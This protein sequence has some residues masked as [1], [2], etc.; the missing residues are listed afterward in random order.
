MDT[1]KPSFVEILDRLHSKEFTMKS[2]MDFMKLKQEESDRVWQSMTTNATA[3]PDGGEGQYQLDAGF[4]GTTKSLNRYHDIL[5]YDHTRVKLQDVAS[6]ADTNDYINASVIESPPEL[7]LPSREGTYIATQGPLPNTVHDF[8]Q[9]VWEQRCRAIVMLTK[10]LE[11]GRCKCEEY[12]PQDT[13]TPI[14]VP[15]LGLKVSLIKDAATLDGGTFEVRQIFVE[16]LGGEVRSPSSLSSDQGNEGSNN[17]PV[18]REGLVVHHFM[19]L[20]W[21]DHGVPASSESLLRFRK[22]VL[23]CTST[24]IAKLLPAADLECV[25][26]PAAL[27]RLAMADSSSRPIKMLPPTGPPV[28]H[29]SAGCGR[30]GTW[31]VIDAAIKYLEHEGD[32]QG[33]LVKDLVRHFRRQR[34]IMVQTWDQFLF[35]YQVIRFAQDNHVSII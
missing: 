20:G 30:T 10:P 5:P 15:G 25:G 18:A 6:R 33:D 16:R 8:W 26:I 7:G 13:H 12:W 34:M 24:H 14:I 4:L 11:N 23:A 19:Y 29:C 9:M 3:P 17:E 21:P 35:C 2:Q 31:C 27:K 32:Y 1:S 22:Y 28:I